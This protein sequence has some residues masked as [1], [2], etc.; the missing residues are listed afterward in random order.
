M[1]PIRAA[2]AAAAFTCLCLAACS[3]ESPLA[4]DFNLVGMEPFWAV[5]ISAEGKTAKFSRPG[6]PD[7]DISFPAETKGEGGAVI[8]TSAS[9][10][11]DIVM[12]LTKKECQDGMSDRKYP[13]E[14]SVVYSG[15]TL[16]GCGASKKFMVENPG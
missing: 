6:E 10:G 7:L 15:R 2:A 11:G 14:A 9:P 3:G 13:Y 12:T 1:P 8:L 4:S 16:K 5:Q